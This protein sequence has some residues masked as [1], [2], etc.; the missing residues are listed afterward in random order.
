MGTYKGEE[1]SGMFSSRPTLPVSAVC[2]QNNH[3]REKDYFQSENLNPSPPKKKNPKASQ[4]AFNFG[5]HLIKFD[6][7]YAKII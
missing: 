4:L 1:P 5:Q 3:V 6:N 7:A 2:A